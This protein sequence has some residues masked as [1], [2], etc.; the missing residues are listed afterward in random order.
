M[1]CV[2]LVPLNQANADNDT[3]RQ[4][5]CSFTTLL[6]LMFCFLDKFGLD[7]FCAS[8]LRI[9]RVSRMRQRR[10]KLE[11]NAP[12]AFDEGILG[13]HLPERDI[14]LG[15]PSRHSTTSGSV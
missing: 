4:D 10:P 7:S 13:N 9:A 1:S 8:R 5:V 2:P 11:Y 6:C 15:Y 14:D 12:L 3:V